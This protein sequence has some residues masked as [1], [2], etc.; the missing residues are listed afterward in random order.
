MRLHLY[1]AAVLAL[2]SPIA[3]A[4]PCQPTWDTAAGNPGIAGGYA[5]PVRLWND[6][7]G[8]RV[9]FGGSFTSAGGSGANR[10][11]SR[12]NP[13][14]GA[15]SPMGSGINPG[16]T[17]AFMTSLV[18]FNPGGGDRL[19][20]GGFY[21]GAGGVA[22]TASLAMWNGT[23]WEAMGTTWEQATRG[24]IWGMT[25][26][27]NRLYVGGGVVNT[28][29]TIAGM[30]WAGMASWDGT[31]WATHITSITG[32]SPYVGALQVF[33]DGSGEALYAAGRFDS[34]NGIPGTSRIARF[35]GATWSSV[36]GGLNSTSTLF[37][38]E[39]LAIFDDGGGPALYA[40]GYASFPSGQPVANV[41]KWNGQSWTSIGGQ[42]GTG[43]L[44]SMVVFDD[45]SGSTLYVG[46]TAMP[47]INYIARWQGGQWQIV[48][49]GITGPAIPPSNFPSVFG[50]GVA[51]DRLYVAGNFTQVNGMAANGLAAWKSCAAPACYPDCNGDAILNL[52]DFGCFQTKFALQDPYADCNG[53]ALLN[54][55]DFGC[56]Q[57]KFALGC[58]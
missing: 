25:V 22:G 41:F 39:A 6:G 10:Y 58:P 44:T 33:N 7:S 24:S 18:T 21:A 36:G 47:Q 49:G 48:G 34:I 46:G 30:P 14:N 56:F 37:G 16:Q 15:W 54:L 19:V 35:N 17:N 13:A 1:T 51:G 52:A 26:W 11:L 9:F 27:N 53:D 23:T 2:S 5:A 8:D 40:A 42:I 32:F 29:G 4:Q 45:G 38:M 57:S 3:L 28:P 12:W 55:A 43:R 50:L 20:A 31:K